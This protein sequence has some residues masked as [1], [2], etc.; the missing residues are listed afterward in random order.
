MGSLIIWIY[1]C[2][3]ML[4]KR[5]ILP[6]FVYFHN[7]KL[8]F[9]IKF[10]IEFNAIMLIVPQEHYTNY[11]SNMHLPSN[12]HQLQWNLDYISNSLYLEKA[13]TINQKEEIIVFY[14]NNIIN[15]E[16]WHSWM[17]CISSIFNH[18]IL[19]NNTTDI[20]RRT[21]IILLLQMKQKIS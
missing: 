17:I 19:D 1:S 20:D 13:L 15:M 11:I 6:V 5:E 4:W 9:E 10:H 7:F 18:P 21:I 12:T 14:R 3:L 2:I 8:S 16:S